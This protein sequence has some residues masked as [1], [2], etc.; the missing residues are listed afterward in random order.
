MVT[1]EHCGE[2]HPESARFCEATGKPMTVVTEPVRPL[3]TE[4]GVF[5]LLV[6]ALAIYRA[7][8]VPLLKTS[9][10]LF[11]P[12]AILAAL[13]AP[14]EGVGWTLVWLAGQA[15]VAL[16]LYGL[17]LPLTQAALTLA[18]TDRLLG[19]DA[20]WREPWLWLGR[21]LGSLLSAAVP[22]ALLLAAG[23]LLGMLPGFVLAFLF[24]F[25]GPVV[26]LEGTGGTAALRRSYQ[27]V[28]SDW[29]R[30]AIMM[31]A[32]GLTR[33][34]AH[35]VADLLVPHG[36]FFAGHLLGDLL[37]LVAMPVPIIGSVLLYLDL[38]RSLDDVT[39]DDLRVK[40]E[41]LRS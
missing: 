24:V 18:V 19:G 7:N 5:D 11:V 28:R 36:A 16:I 14:L 29:L 32:F 38:R 8:L 35:G 21:R 3:E 2:R 4:K 23:F 13:A 22:G 37:L 12:G 10:V 20:G 30:T 9:A 40:L 17:T 15:L 34:L 1:C 33:A 27:L 26:L 31:L 6:Q 39:D 25:V 41:T